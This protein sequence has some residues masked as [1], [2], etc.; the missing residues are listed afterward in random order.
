MSYFRASVVDVPKTRLAMQGRRLSREISTDFE[1]KVLLRVG[2]AH[3]TATW[4]TRSRFKGS[5]IQWGGGAVSRPAY[6]HKPNRRHTILIT[7]KEKEIE[8]WPGGWNI[9]GHLWERLPTSRSVASTGSVW[10]CVWES[11]KSD[12]RPRP[13][14]GSVRQRLIRHGTM[15]AV[16]IDTLRRGRPTF[17]PASFGPR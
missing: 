11:S 4:F 15:A 7:Q 16:S 2:N 8:H 3:V 6:F 17:S 1:Y 13:A 9:S 12:S 10:S 14:A 5:N